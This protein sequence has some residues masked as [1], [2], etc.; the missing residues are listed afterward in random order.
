MTVLTDEIDPRYLPP[1]DRCS[2][3]KVLYM[4]N[5]AVMPLHQGKGIGRRL[6]VAALD[7]FK[8]DAVLTVHVE[9]DSA[10]HLYHSLG[11]R[12]YGVAKAHINCGDDG[13]LEDAYVMKRVWKPLTKKQRGLV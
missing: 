11:F 6:M 4:T 13:E 5:V 10:L 7:K 2:G 3:S 8:L 1:A 9:N 12:V